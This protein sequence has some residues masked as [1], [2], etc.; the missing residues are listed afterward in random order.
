MN[1]DKFK[2]IFWGVRG[3]RPVPGKDTIKFG[4]NTSCVELILGKK[5]LILDA[6][7]G[8]CNLGDYLQQKYKNKT[9]EADIFISHTHWDHIQG[10][11]FFQPAWKKNNIF[12]LYG[13]SNHT[14]TDIKNLLERQ[15]EPSFFPVS[16]SEMRA[17]IKFHYFK[18]DKIIRPGK[19]ITVK[20]LYNPH[21]SETSHL[22]R[23]EYD[24]HSCCYITD[25]EHSPQF[26]NQLINFIKY[27]DLLIYD[28]NFTDDEYEGKGNE[29]ALKGWGHSTWQQGIKYARAA[30]VKK[31]IF[32]HHATHRK[33]DELARI[34][35]KAS[36]DYN[37]AA[38]REG[39]VISL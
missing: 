5:I 25:F 9:I 14:K 35:K 23:I 21:H 20:S 7:T 4:G 30:G 2:V 16:F 10:F 8:I 15:M 39:M 26:E 37:C 27:T 38:A 22:L 3:S 29:P 12:N 34:E 13:R 33:D 18:K 17:E 32:F 11:P 1:K 36:T 28:A 6:G 24:G 19:D 31:L